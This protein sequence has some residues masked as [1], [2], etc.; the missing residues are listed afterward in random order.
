MTDKQL[1]NLKPA[2]KGEVRN[3]SGKP[4]GTLNNKTILN[5]YLALEEEITNPITGKLEKFSQYEIIYLQLIE[6]AKKGNLKALKELL[7]RYEGK[8][9]QQLEINQSNEEHVTLKILEAYGIKAGEFIIN[10]DEVA[11]LKRIASGEVL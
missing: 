5:K 8:A 3:P 1:Q 4:K 11:V 7:D 2:K 9:H 6:Q 10:S